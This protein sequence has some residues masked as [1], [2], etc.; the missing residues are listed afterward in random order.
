MS[1]P[2]VTSVVPGQELLQFHKNTVFDL[3]HRKAD[4]LSIAARIK[5]DFPDG[6]IDKGG[7]QSF[8]DRIIIG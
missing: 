5:F 4:A 8:L 6:R 7:L 3:V 1:A 2:Y